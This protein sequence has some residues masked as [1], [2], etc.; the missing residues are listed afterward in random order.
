VEGKISSS[1][2]KEAAIQ[3][4]L[5]TL[6]SQERKKL[7]L[8]ALGTFWGLSLLTIPLPPI[9]WVTV[10]GFFFF[11]IYWAIRKLR[12]DVHFEAFAFPCPE[13]A[14]EVRVVPQVRRN[15]LAFVC[16]H[17]RYGLKLEF[18]EN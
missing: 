8:K 15:P 10:P 5:R 6:S 9:H 12:E 14:Q 4:S 16:P 7:A 17:C 18:Q 2:G 3:F 1:S 11:G 13:C